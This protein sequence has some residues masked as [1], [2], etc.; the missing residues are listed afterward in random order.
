MA[1]AATLNPPT[2]KW[3][4]LDAISAHTNHVGTKELIEIMKA[5]KSLL[6]VAADLVG[7]DGV[8]YTKEDLFKLIREIGP[9]IAAL[10][11]HTDLCRDF[12]VA[13]PNGKTGAQEL[14]EFAKHYNF[15]VIEDRKLGDIGD[16]AKRILHT[17]PHADFVTIHGISGGEAIEAMCK[18]ASEI[19]M[20]L[21]PVIE[22]SNKGNLVWKITDDL[23]EIVNRPEMSDCL[24]CLVGQ[25]KDVGFKL[26]CTPGIST[27]EKTSGDQQYN[28]PEH[29]IE[30]NGTRLLIVGSDIYKM[31]DPLARLAKVQ[32]INARSWSA[33]ECSI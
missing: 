12:F 32:A 23:M 26:K 24:T 20:G 16:I 29:R 1:A 31:T 2:L 14:K 28:T 7:D 22:M 4:S 8:A 27:S 5:K 25:E 18:V 10:K 9:E 3:P 11:V 33:Y 17:F 13:G 30:Q 15:K 21:I 6:C 19:G